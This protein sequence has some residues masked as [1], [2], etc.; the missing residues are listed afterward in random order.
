[1]PLLQ[2]RL[3]RTRHEELA[4]GIDEFLAIARDRLETR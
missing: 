1:V 2:S 4:T 3:G